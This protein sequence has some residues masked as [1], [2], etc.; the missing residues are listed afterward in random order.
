MIPK[1]SKA[2]SA[3]ATGLGSGSLAAASHAKQMGVS[4]NGGPKYTT[5]NGRILNISTPKYG[6]LIFGNSQI[7]LRA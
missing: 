1:S 7:G 4:E 5:L 2:G 3:L 6:T